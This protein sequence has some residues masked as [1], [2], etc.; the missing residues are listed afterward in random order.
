MREKQRENTEALSE[1]RWLIDEYTVPGQAILTTQEHMNDDDII[2][3]FIFE[4]AVEG[5]RYCI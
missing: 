1:A 2:I 3:G 4:V 5:K